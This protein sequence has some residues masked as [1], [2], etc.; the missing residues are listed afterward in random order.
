MKIDFGADV[1]EGA[2][3]TWLEQVAASRGAGALVWMIASTGV[4]GQPYPDYDHYTVYSP[5]DAPAIRNFA[6]TLPSLS[7]TA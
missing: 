4:D 5:D 7:P 6:Q 1:R 3:E 2:Y